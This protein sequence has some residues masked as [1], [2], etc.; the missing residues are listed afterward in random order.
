MMVD[1]RKSKRDQITHLLRV[2]DFQALANLAGRGGGVVTTLVQ[3]LYQP[4]D[5]L[6][7]RATEAL[8]FIAQAHPKRIEKIIGRLLWSLNEDSGSFGWGA[9]AVLGEIGRNNIKLVEEI[10]LMLFNCLEEEFSREGMLWGLGRLG[11]VHPQVVRQAAPRIQACLADSNP[12]VITHAVWCLGIIGVQ[13]ASSD[14]RR[15]VDNPQPVRL[16]EDGVLRDTTVGQISA[17]ALER[18]ASY[19]ETDI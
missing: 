11:Q 16:Y 14:I 17:E 2:S 10:I 9:A 5:L 19:P 12:Q 7:W 13:E 18:L 3:M 1:T 8:G 15:L 6:H 4:D